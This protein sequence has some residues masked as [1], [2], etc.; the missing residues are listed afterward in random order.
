MG[1]T[2]DVAL[3][4]PSPSVGID[5]VAAFEN[6]LEFAV[7]E[8]V[9]GLSKRCRKVY[10]DAEITLSNQM[11]T[12][13]VAGVGCKIETKEVVAVTEGITRH[14]VAFVLDMFTGGGELVVVALNVA[15]VLEVWLASSRKFMALLLALKGFLA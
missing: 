5:D 8:H 15:P 1:R 7:D 2:L 13:S 9:H 14:F 4:G 6:R 10:L 12:T 3:S 11:E